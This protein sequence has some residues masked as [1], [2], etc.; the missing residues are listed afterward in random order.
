[1][2]SSTPD[3]SAGKQ[4][5][6]PTWTTE[7]LQDRLE[8][9]TGMTLRLT[10][11]DNSRCMVRMSHGATNGARSLRLHRMFL[12]APSG[13]VHALGDWLVRPQRTASGEKVDAFL[14]EH[15]HLV[16]K[17]P[18]REEAVRTRGAV[19]DLERLAAEVNATFFDGVIGSRITWGRRTRSRK[20]R[21]TIRFGSYHYQ[22]DIIRI[23]AA[24]DDAF[25]PEWVVRFVIYHEMLHA[26][27]GIRRSAN[28]RREYHGAEFRAMERQHPDYERVRAWERDPSNLERLMEG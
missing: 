13:V 23:H 25:V 19:H 21:R 4:L 7:E 1:M 20:R 27:L 26:Y 2:P 6:L 12:H 10:I 17:P 11:T 24:L 16:R 18:P 5:E 8:A 9:E 28:G 14:R 3:P 15:A 22:G